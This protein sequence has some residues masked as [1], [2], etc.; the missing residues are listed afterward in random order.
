MLWKELAVA[1]LGLSSVFGLPA[2][3]AQVLRYAGTIERSEVAPLGGAHGV[4]VAPDGSRIFAVAFDDNAL[5]VW[6]RDARTGSLTFAQAFVEGVGGISGLFRAVRVT[7]SPDGTGVYVGAFFGDSVAVFRRDSQGFLR[8]E[9]A[10]FGGASGLFG[11]TQVRDLEFSPDGRFLYVASYGDNAVLV[12]ERSERDGSL[13]P[14]E[15]VSDRDEGGTVPG[16]VRPTSLAVSPDGQQVYTACTGSQSLVVFERDA[17]SGTLVHEATFFQGDGGI[18]GL[19]GAEALAVSPDGRDVYVAGGDGVA[20][21]AR[22]PEGVLYVRSMDG[23]VVGESGVA[24][25]S[26]FALTPQGNYAFLTRAGDDTLVVLQRDPS[27]GALELVELH[28]AADE[29]RPGL[30]GASSV[31][32]SPDGR[33]VYV[34]GQFDDAVGVFRRIPAC[35]GDCDEDGEVTVDELTR[36]VRVALRQTVDLDCWQADRDAD[37]ELTVDEIVAAVRRALVGCGG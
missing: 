5:L 13:R 23:E 19:S 10:L 26:D 35:L 29:P 16:L 8:F 15:V 24:G 36:A 11:L 17:R 2:A 28:R 37:G 7:T 6:V 18:R 21:F 20:H 4:S 3:Y 22:R 12:L 14:T 32:V 30:R 34:A 31:A 1:C 25:P 27:S 33:W 9:Q